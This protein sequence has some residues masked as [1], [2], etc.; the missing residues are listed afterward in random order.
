MNDESTVGVELTTYRQRHK[1]LSLKRNQKGPLELDKTAPSSFL[2][3]NWRTMRLSKLTGTL[4][5]SPRV[6]T[7]RLRSKR[8][9]LWSGSYE[10]RQSGPRPKPIFEIIRI[11][12]PRRLSNSVALLKKLDMHGV[13]TLVS[14]IW[15]ICECSGERICC[16]AA[17][18]SFTDG[19]GLANTALVLGMPQEHLRSKKVT[20]QS[21]W[22]QRVFV[23]HRGDW[24]IWVSNP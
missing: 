9:S 23:S 3:C 24:S 19:A 22:W 15:S 17:R 4:L 16:V 20:C 13:I 11:G 5:M 12:L 2:W 8:W 18:A 21:P 6:I 1:R 10:H 7:K 14:I